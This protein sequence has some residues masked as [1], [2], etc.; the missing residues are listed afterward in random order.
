MKG[1][2][3]LNAKRQK[4]LI[5]D[6][7]VIFIRILSEILSEQYDIITAVNGKEALSAAKSSA[8]PDI[9]LLDIVLPD[10]D[11][12][13]IC[14]KLKSDMGT[15]DIPV[16]FITGMNSEKDEE[17]GLSVGA[18]D[19]ITKPFSR[20]IVKARIKNHLELKKLRDMLQI[21]SFMDS[22]TEL[23]NRR[24]F[25]EMLRLQWKHCLEIHK[26]ISVIMVDIDY[27]KA[28]NDT[29]GHL[30]GDECLKDI[31]IQLNDAVSG[32]NNFICRW[33]GEEFYCLMPLVGLEDAREFAENLRKQIEQMSIPHTASRDFENVTISLGVSSVV[34][35]KDDNMITLLQ[36]ADK[37][38]YEAKN[39]GRNC[40]SCY[41]DIII[42]TNDGI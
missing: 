35:H 36:Q 20:P 8:P 17:Y 40:V 12:Y 25:D 28:F 31:S 11:G 21:N 30:A 4:V 32:T 33:G 37:A 13:E 16:V 38:L 1:D 14:R 3:C 29:Y 27:F 5:V 26:P 24:K 15:K 22:L 41:G 39:I 19:Y 6:D 23:P 2:K 34:P 10:M 7:T 18:I 9:I 42:Q